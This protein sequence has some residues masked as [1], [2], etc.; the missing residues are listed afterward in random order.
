M[1]IISLKPRA[2]RLFVF[3][4]VGLFA[5]E[6]TAQNIHTRLNADSL[7]VG[8]IFEYSLILQ[9]DQEYQKVIYPDTNTFPSSLELIER[10]QFKVSEFSDS[11]VYKLQFFDNKDTR[12]S[13]LPVSLISSEDST[14][15]FTDPVTL[16]FKS[17]VAEGDTTLKPMKPNFSFQRAWWPWILAALLIGA[18]LYWWFKM[19]EKP[20][21]AEPDPEPE[22]PPFYNPVEELEKTLISLKKDSNIAETKDFKLFYSEL[23]DAIRKYFEDLYQIPALE[24]TTTELLRYLDAYGIDEALNDK[25][26]I[27]LRRADL[28]KFAKYT[29]TLDDA[30]K[31]YDEA[32]AFLERAKL[33]DS[34]RIS[35]LKAQYRMKYA[36]HSPQN[37]NEVNE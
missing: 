32:I 22:I 33:A 27:I 16:Y 18:F 35:R 10:Q 36:Q 3:L 5:A 31:T 21:Q 14:T 17:V 2:L 24:S 30:W 25:T 12:I 7:T 19:R 15:I 37:E 28:V 34:A 26:R 1:K 11:L 9:Y 8:E 23:S 29:P 4:V 6:V 13:P 20:Q